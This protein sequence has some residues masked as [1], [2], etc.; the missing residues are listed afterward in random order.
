[1]LERQYFKK[2]SRF[3]LKTLGLFAFESV[4]S[5]LFASFLDS[6]K[7]AK[8]LCLLGK[9][10][11]PGIAVVSS[12][13]IRLRLRVNKFATTCHRFLKGHKIMA[14]V[15]ST[16]FPVID[17][18]PQKFVAN[19]FQAKEADSQSATQRVLR[20]KQYPSHLVLLVKTK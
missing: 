4:F 7:C 2:P 9:I 13:F 16:W 18:N 12:E 3:A 5:P 6:L 1:M 11:K 19:I 10:S 15:Q 14:Q 17:R 8:C 20:S